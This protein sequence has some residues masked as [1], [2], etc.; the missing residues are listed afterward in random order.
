MSKLLPHQAANVAILVGML[1]N[2]PAE[3]YDH[4]D[5][6]FGYARR[7]EQTCGCALGL[8]N[9]NREAF[10]VPGPDGELVSA[11][12]LDCWPFDWSDEVFGEASHF[13]AFSLSAFAPVYA[14]AVTKD[15]VVER[16]NKL[17]QPAE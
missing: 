17:L 8:A 14:S 2:L 3:N 10:T 4:T 11:D 6:G 15:M 7:G 13:E 5:F 12:N 16:L 9:V 1:G